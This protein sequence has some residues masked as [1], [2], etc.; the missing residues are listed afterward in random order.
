MST[1]LTLAECAAW[2][3]VSE[4]SIRD[5]VRSGRIPCVRLSSRILRFDKATITAKLG[6]KDASK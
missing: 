4:R 1:L 2:L 3:R 5:A 6:I